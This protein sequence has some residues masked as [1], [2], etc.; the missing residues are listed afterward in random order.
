[1]RM[2]VIVLA[3]L[4]AACSG[5]SQPPEQ[6]KTPKAITV[7]PY[8]T[9]IEKFRQQREAKL[10]SDT[11][12]LTIAGLSFLTKPE[13]TVGSDAANDVVLP[14]SA[15]PRV[16]TFALAKNGKVSVTL[17]PGVTVKLLDGKP[18]SGG[19]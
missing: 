6:E 17:E 3:M 18:F 16:G 7:D 2:T 9:D 5:P 4:A 12:W 13:T 1:M 10:T 14:A 11:G 8:R 15:P 19:P